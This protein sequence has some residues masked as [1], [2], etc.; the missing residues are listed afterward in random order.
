LILVFVIYC[1]FSGFVVTMD[2]ITNNFDN[3]KVNG[4]KKEA[5]KDMVGT[6]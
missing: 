3:N 6:A 2:K 5:G 1:I 4:R